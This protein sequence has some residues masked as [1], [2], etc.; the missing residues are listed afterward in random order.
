MSRWY[1]EA[2]NHTCGDFARGVD[3]LSA[4]GLTPLASTKVAPPRVAE[5]AIALEC[6]V[7]AVHDVADAS[8]TATS[9]VV[10]GEVVMVHI[11]EAVAGRS[12]GTGKLVVDPLKLAPVCRLGGVT[13]AELGELYDI[14][15]PDGAGRYGGGARAPGAAAA[16]AAA[17]PGAK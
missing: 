17:A 5:A 15:R 9:A 1:V 11:A 7:R 12:P 8:G 16:A 14:G 4:A 2:A 3:E 10:I 13:Y 6:R